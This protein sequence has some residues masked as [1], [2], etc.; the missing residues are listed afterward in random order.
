LHSEHQPFLASSSRL[1]RPHATGEIVA[2][3]SAIHA[4][5]EMVFARRTV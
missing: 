1:L 2:E 5:V 3:A 4:R